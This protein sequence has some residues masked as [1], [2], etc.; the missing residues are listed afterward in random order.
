MIRIL[1]ELAF[2]PLKQ[3]ECIGG[4]TGKS[5]DD[6]AFA[7]SAYLARVAFH[8]RIAKA[9]LPVAGN[10]DLAILADSDNRGSIHG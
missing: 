4:G 2:Q 6:I 8:D 10:D 7:E 5:G 3:G 9:D 1:L